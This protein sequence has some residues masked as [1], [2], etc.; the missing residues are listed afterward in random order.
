MRSSQL[1]V[2]KEIVLPDLCR[3]MKGMGMLS[4]KSA[5]SCTSSG[6]ASTNECE[7]LLSEGQNNCL[8]GRL[9]RGSLRLDPETISHITAVTE[10][11]GVPRNNYCNALCPGKSNNC[12]H[13]SYASCMCIHV[14]DL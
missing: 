6:N 9:D 7:S 11:R 2:S 14:L 4:T 3:T 10:A 1:G 13:Y 12:L 8:N 5:I